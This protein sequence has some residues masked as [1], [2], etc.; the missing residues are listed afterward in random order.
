VQKAKLFEDFRNVYKMKW[1]KKNDIY[2]NDEVGC[3]LNVLTPQNIADDSDRLVGKI[4]KEKRSDYREKKPLLL[5]L[6]R[7]GAGILPYVSGSLRKCLIKNEHDGN[8][9][10]IPIKVSR[11]QKG[12]L[13]KEGNIFIDKT[14]IK[15]ALRSLK[16]HEEGIIIDDVFDKGHT[17]KE[18]KTLLEESGKNI[19][20]ATL[21]R[22][23]YANETDV[24]ADF[25]VRN[26]RERIICG[27]KYSCWLVFPWERDD[28]TRKMW[29]E[30]YPKSF[31]LS[32]M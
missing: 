9:D 22:K 10:Y 19:I 21:Y 3:Y 20:I 30:M 15:Q 27:K 17:G 5:P 16:D 14:D 6:T 32:N 11:Y 4:L 31:F 23:P 28:H 1:V 8:I 25:F 7:G 12:K 29:E 2:V 24:D 26:Y 13:N 18:T